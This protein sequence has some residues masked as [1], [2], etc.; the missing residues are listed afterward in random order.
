M[1]DS[2]FNGNEM[3]VHFDDYGVY[4]LFLDK[5]DYSV[6]KAPHQLAD[7]RRG[8]SL[9]VTKNIGN[10]EKEDVVLQCKNKANGKTCNVNVYICNR[11][12]NKTEEDRDFEIEEDRNFEKEEGLLSCNASR[13]LGLIFS[14]EDVTDFQ[15]TIQTQQDIIQ[16]QEEIQQ[17]QQK[18][19]QQLQ[20]QAQQQQQ[21]IQQLQQQVQQQQQVIQQLQQQV[22]QL[23]QP[24][25]PQ[26]P[27]ALRRSTRKTRTPDYLAEYESVPKKQKK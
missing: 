22:Q 20:Q 11:E 9:K 10:G 7:K 21:V 23:L 5:G 6:E 3:A 25:Q 14:A 4:G 24:Q 16:I 1:A 8:V 27:V 12:M 18:E 19:I 17:V 15:Q 26:Q 2:G 13:A